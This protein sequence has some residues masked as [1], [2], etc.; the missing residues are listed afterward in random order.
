MLD[1]I[2]N[3]VLKYKGKIY[4]TK[5]SRITKKNFLK[6]NKEFNNKIYSNFRKKINYHF[7]SIQSKRLGI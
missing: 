3:I 1:E 6:I 5:D 7:S 2:D 4:L